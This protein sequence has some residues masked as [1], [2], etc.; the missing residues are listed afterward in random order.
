[1][2]T[3]TAGVRDTKGESA[4]LGARDSTRANRDRPSS[5]ASMRTPDPDRVRN[6]AC[7]RLQLDTDGALVEVL[8]G[9]VGRR[10]EE[11]D[12][13]RSPRGAEFSRRFT[14]LTLKGV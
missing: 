1:M 12:K 14:R 10:A 13:R 5:L 8:C 4:R 3:H 9:I 2:R 6:T 7:E 11:Y